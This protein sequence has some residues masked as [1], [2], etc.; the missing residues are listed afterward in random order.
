MYRYPTEIDAGKLDHLSRWIKLKTEQGAGD[1][2]HIVDE[3]HRFIDSRIGCVE[4]QP[5]DPDLALCE[6]ADLDAIRSLRPAG[7]RRIWA[8]LPRQ[9]YLRRLQGAMFSRFAGCTLG[10]PVEL[11]SVEAMEAWASYVGDEFPPV[12]Y[13]LQ[14]DR[15]SATR[16]AVS[17]RED[18][19]RGRIRHVP[20]D[21]DVGYTILGL[22]ILEECGPDFTTADVAAT[23]QKY[24]LR[25]CAYTAERI[26]YDNLTRGL[27]PSIAGE[28]GNYDRQLIGAGIRCDPWAYAAPGW[29][30]KAAELAYRDAFTSH[31]RNG[32]YGSMYFA[33]AISAAFTVD[34]PVEALH[35]G[36]QEIPSDCLLAREVKWALAEAPNIKGYRDGHAAVNER[37][38]GMNR[39]HTINNAVLTVWGI[40][41][42]G[43]DVTSVLSQTV[44]MGYDN[45]CTA[46]TAGSI[47]GA[48]V[49]I[50]NVPERWYKPFN[51]KVRIYL[52]DRN[53]FELDDL[54]QR[55]ASQAG[56]MF[57]SSGD[58]DWRRRSAE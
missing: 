4:T 51:N 29:P 22:L 27:D 15:P 9:E 50:D 10:S 31:R 21:D 55:F 12:D 57:A 47:V 23:W 7:V 36:L 8:E 56:T 48:A 16:Y 6:P 35:I 54:V 2:Q 46:A 24:F 44:A 45:D 30:E 33:A 18:L 41:I 52:K 25:D 37:F 26:T 34:D 5:D 43:R 38:A 39:V 40:T 13:W 17:L 28:T 20:S 3:V 19:A 49:G 53:D 1:L 11:H 42:G 58:S 14:V 32:I